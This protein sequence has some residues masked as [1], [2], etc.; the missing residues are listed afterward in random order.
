MTIP[1][2]P[3]QPFVD[4]V[5]TITAD[6]ANTWRAN[7]AKA[8]D[9][10][11]GSVGTAYTP[12]TSIDVGGAGIEMSGPLVLVAGGDMDVETGV[13]VQFKSGSTLDIDSG[14]TVTRQGAEV[15]S[16]AEATTAWR[17][18]D[19]A[20][21]H[22]TYDVSVDEVKVP[23]VLSVSPTL[24]TLRSASAPV[25]VVGNRIRFSRNGSA[26]SG[27]L[28]IQRDPSGTIA[29]LPSSGFSFVEFCYMTSPDDATARWRVVAAGGDAQVTAAG[30]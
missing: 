7:M 6:T 11:A 20:D 5:S 8:G 4:D 21:A 29:D 10:V 2:V 13:T 16:G 15:I 22:T 24:Y 30:G 19:G 17:T 28:R 18:A 26:M 9:F 27:S 3:S 23:A 14:A 25:P 1:L 12:A